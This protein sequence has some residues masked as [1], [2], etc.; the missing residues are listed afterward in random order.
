LNNG[1]NWSQ[2]VL[3]GSS[4]IR[5]NT[6]QASAALL[7]SAIWNN[8]T[9]GFGNRQGAAFTF[10][11]APLTGLLNPGLILKGSGGSA[12]GPANYILVSYASGAVTVATTTNS[13]V[14][15]TT[16]ATFPATVVSGDTL[17]AVALA[18]GSVFVYQN[19]SQIGTVLIPTA[20]AGSWTQGT[21]GGRIGMQLPTNQRVDDFKGAT[22]P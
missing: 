21:A 17:S 8:P 1:T 3:L 12:T 14:T 5:V 13:G 15:L 6:N 7:G 11:N 10:A 2:T 22:V 20:G 16:R 9:G 19:A 18:D 4:S